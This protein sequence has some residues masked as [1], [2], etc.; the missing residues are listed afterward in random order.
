MFS[1]IIKASEDR[2]CQVFRR[3]DELNVCAC[4]HCEG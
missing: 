4:M 3:N 2:F 1:A